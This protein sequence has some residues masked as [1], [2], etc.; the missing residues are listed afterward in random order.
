VTVGFN[1]TPVAVEVAQ[2]IYVDNIEEINDRN[3]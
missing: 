2:E 1:S 3:N